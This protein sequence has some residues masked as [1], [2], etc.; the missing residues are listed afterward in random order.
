MRKIAAII[1]RGAGSF[2]DETLLNEVRAA[3]SRQGVDARVL[4]ASGSALSS[5]A[6]SLLEEDFEVIAA[7][8]GDGTVSSVASVL[9]GS[10]AAL[11]VLP[12]GT[13]NHFARDL[14]VPLD[15]QSAVSLICSGAT[16]IVDVGWMNGHTFLNN[17]S[18]GLYPD[19]VRLRLRWCDRIGKWPALVVAS[20][21]VLARFRY[22]RITAELNGK[23]IAR[24][25]PMVLISNNEYKFE[26]GNLTERERLDKGVLGVYL[27]RDEGRTGLIRIALHSL[28]FNL[29]QAT[30][31]ESDK[32]A[33][34]IITMRRR[35]IRVALDGELYKMS[36]P[37]VY[38]SVPG[39]LRV[40]APTKE[41]PILES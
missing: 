38:R 23:R 29:E 8:G 26:P 25:C 18:L 5:I 12:L 19:Q 16:K 28:V 14:G 33:E 9:V 13:L 21:A 22:L 11:G 17:S 41:A 36:P 37:L 24:R 6:R 4:T 2:S 10:Q 1:N 3:F 34:A 7:G 15:L 31:F 20:I 40:I 39:G 35:R 27:L 32:A 30:S